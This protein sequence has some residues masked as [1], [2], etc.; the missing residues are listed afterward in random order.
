MTR[1]QTALLLLAPIGVLGSQNA[2]H[3]IFDYIDPLIGTVNGGHVFPGA[4]LPYGMAKAVADVNTELQGGF[5][6]DDSEITGFSHMHDSG[7]GGSPSLGNF[8]IF[9]HAG[10][11]DDVLDNCKFAEHERASKRINGT[12]VASP[13]Y[14]AVTLNTSVRAEMTVSNHTALYRFT[15]PSAARQN[16]SIN[17]GG[18]T[19]P[20]VNQSS[21]AV[22]S[23]PYSPLVLVDLKDLP[24]S[25]SNGSIAVD[26]ATGRIV[27]NGTFNPS[28]GVGTYDLHFCADFRGGDSSKNGGGGGGW[29]IR[30][31]GVFANNRAGNLPKSLRTYPDGVDL[32]PPVPAGAWVQFTPSPDAHG[33]SNNSSADQLLVR[34]GVSF[35][36]TAQACANAEREIGDFDFDGTRQTA[37]SAWRAKL[38]TVQV[39]DTGVNATFRT[40]FWSGIYRTMLSPQDYTGENPLWASDEPYYDSFYCLWDSFRSTHPLLTLLDPHTQTRMVRSLIDTYRHEGWLPDCRMS[41]C[42]GFTQ[43]GSNAD[44]VLA[45]AFVKNLTEGID[46]T[47]GYE[48]VVK[49]AEVEPPVWS[50]EGRGGLASWKR[51][52]YI[53]AD[54]FDVAGVGPFTR[55]ISRTVE[56]AYNDFCIAQMARARGHD[57]D[58]ATYLQRSTN[59]ANLF[60]ADQRSA[61]PLGPPLPPPPPPPPPP[62]QEPCQEPADERDGP[63]NTLVDSGFAGFLQPRYL[64]GTFGYQDPA[65]CQPLFNFTACYLTTTGHETYEGGSWLYTFYAPHDMAGLIA[66]LGGPAAFTARLRYAHDT[67]DLLYLGDEQ[68]FLLVYLFHY[69]GRPGLSATYA[70][71]YIPSQFN[72]TLVGIPGND[73]SGAMG[74]FAAFSMMGLW[75]VSGQNVYLL[76]APFFREV[77]VTS[78]VTGR[79]ATVR[80]TNFDPAY[81]AIYIQSATLNGRPYTRNWIDHAFFADGGVLEL[82]LGLQESTTWGTADADLPP[83]TSVTMSSPREG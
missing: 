1:L 33:G 21:A 45:D 13:G 72:D 10:C 9:A 62:G 16:T 80:C 14:F 36:S 25:R 68:A 32:S 59:W 17:A 46:W 63:H 37:E 4:S 47:T 60:K 44:V 77:N 75:P 2:S 49:D 57:A 71:R 42:K 48:A 30:D 34:V 19:R 73:D 24:G 50:V 6:S 35:I 39:D 8:P 12:V 56:Y 51:L 61:L 69:A 66:R 22:Q 64:N 7:T 3:D 20:W 82:T 83:S 15:F 5:A 81:R 43:G 18:A 76:T 67:P 29:S 28:F 31:T 38:A 55:S 65:L 78:A 23:L 58:A 52:G 53:P 79:T 74:A 26:P 54:D 40:V 70:H 41:L 11:A 27:G